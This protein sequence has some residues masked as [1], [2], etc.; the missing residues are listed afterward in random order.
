MP[1]TTIKS[2]EKGVKRKLRDRE[3]IP[4]CMIYYSKISKQND[5]FTPSGNVRGGPNGK[6][7][8]ILDVRD[9]RLNEPIDSPLHMKPLCDQIKENLDNVSLATTGYHRRWYQNFT[10]NL[11]KLQAT[12]I[13]PSTSTE[14][15][16]SPRKRR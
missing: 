3:L 6:L 13:Q 11:N 1:E 9:C 5:E 8:H 16:L 4:I 7:Q 15:S 12:M 10:L 14:S 2:M